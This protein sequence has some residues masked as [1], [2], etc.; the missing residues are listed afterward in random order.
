M[1]PL[2]VLYTNII[3]TIEALEQLYRQYDY[4]EVRCV[5]SKQHQ[6]SSS[7]VSRRSGNFA[8]SCNTGALQEIADE[9]E[10]TELHSS[11]QSNVASNT[12]HRDN[13]SLDEC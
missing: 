7:V 11:H 6:E 4:F 9:I 2:G 10:V 3:E 1:H 13:S 8:Y 12:T 5:R